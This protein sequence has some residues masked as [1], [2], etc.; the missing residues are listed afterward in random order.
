MLP[1]QVGALTLTVWVSLAD[2]PLVQVTAMLTV[3]LPA[4]SPRMVAFA[5][6]LLPLMDMALLDSDQRQDDA[7]P[8]PGS[9]VKLNRTVLPRSTEVGPVIRP[10]HG[11]PVTVMLWVSRAVPP[12]V[13]VTDTV[14]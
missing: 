14:T 11:G 5:P 3:P 12:L 10:P 2:P 4:L 7:I 13:Q 9:I 6:V 1:A 8:S